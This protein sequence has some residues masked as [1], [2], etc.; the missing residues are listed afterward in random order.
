MIFTSSN[1]SARFSPWLKIKRS[2]LNSIG[3]VRSD[4]NEP[5]PAF[6]ENAVLDSKAANKKIFPSVDKS[7]LLKRLTIA[8][9]HL[10]AFSKTYN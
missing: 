9:Y 7:L 3:S 1:N 5:K 2:E 4:A 8:V 10:N 6:C